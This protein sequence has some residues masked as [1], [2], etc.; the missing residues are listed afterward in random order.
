MAVVSREAPRPP[1]PKGGLG[2][3]A[4]P[5]QTFRQAVDLSINAGIVSMASAMK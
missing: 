5:A 1:M 4:K 2:G 3:S